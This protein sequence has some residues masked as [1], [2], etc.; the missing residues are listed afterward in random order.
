MSDATD[1]YSLGETASKKKSKRPQLIYST[2]ETFLRTEAVPNDSK[3]YYIRPPLV[4]TSY[5][6]WNDLIENNSIITNIIT[7][8]IKEILDKKITQDEAQN[9]GYAIVES[10]QMAERRDECIML[11]QKRIQ[12]RWNYNFPKSEML[13]ALED[14]PKL[15]KAALNYFRALISQA[16]VSDVKRNAYDNENAELYSQKFDDAIDKSFLKM[17]RPKS[18]DAI[19]Q[20]NLYR[21]KLREFLKLNIDFKMPDP[22]YAERK[23]ERTDSRGRQNTNTSQQKTRSKS[24]Y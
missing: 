16:K 12:T 3:I 8:K 4:Y 11:L 1:E 17:K 14:D 15:Y 24:T 2:Y 19:E 9:I 23:Q 10:L 22:K 20:H 18:S 13:C 7:S 5:D 21:T 6:D